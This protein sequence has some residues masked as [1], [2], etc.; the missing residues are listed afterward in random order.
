MQRWGANLLGVEPKLTDEVVGIYRH[1]W[2]YSSERACREL[3]YRITPFEQAIE[4]TVEWLR[5]A[6]RL[7]GKG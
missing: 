3:G 4:A 5:D 2:A 1:E 6:G 7:P